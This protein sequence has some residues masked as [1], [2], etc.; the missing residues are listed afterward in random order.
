MKTKTITLYKFDE[1]SDDLKRKVLMNYYD[2]NVDYEWWDSTYDDAKRIGLKITEFSDHY[3]R[4]HFTEDALFTANAIIK[5]HGEECETF[6]TATAFLIERDEIVNTAPKD[7]NG[8]FKDEYELDSKL[9][10]VEEDFRL[11]LLEDYRVILLKEYEYL[12]S[13]EAIAE[14]LKANEY[15]FNDQGKIDNG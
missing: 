3:C 9:D 6:K 8:E 14:T 5:E 4:G 13:E 7:E 11:A 15:H 12:T 10:Q 1:L 2:I